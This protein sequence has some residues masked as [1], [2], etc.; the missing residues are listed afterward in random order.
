MIDLKKYNYF[1]GDKSEVS[2]GVSQIVNFLDLAGHNYVLFTPPRTTDSNKIYDIC[3]YHYLS[4]KIEFQNLEDFKEKILNKSNLFRVD[5]IVF[6][7]WSKM[8][9]EPFL[10]E[11]KSL[12]QKFIIV[13]K[14]FNYKSTDDVND[15]NIR[16]EYKSLK[17]SVI[18]LTDNQKNQSNNIESLKM[19]YIRD[20][21]LEYLFKKEN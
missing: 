9:W 10:N 2:S 4:N 5:L 11:I 14:E 15:F 17:N 16:R 6:D 8:D 19:S 21:K 1:T 7:F 18:W 12:P 3:L 13:T 20:K